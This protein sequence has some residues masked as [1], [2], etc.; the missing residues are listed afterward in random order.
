VLIQ[1]PTFV[2]ILGT[3]KIYR[4]RENTAAADLK[5]SEADIS[6]ITADSNAIDLNADRYP[7]AMQRWINR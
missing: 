3:T 5:L 7:E 4:L 2:P 1:Q 6:D